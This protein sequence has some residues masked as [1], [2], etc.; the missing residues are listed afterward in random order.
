MA[1]PWAT[2]GLVVALV[3]VHLGTGAWVWAEGLA[4]PWSAWVGERSARTR[5][6]VGGRYLP[7]DRAQPWRFAST[8]W[9]H[10]DLLHLLVN[11]LAVA[12]V[13]RWVEPALGA[14][15][16]LGLFAVGGVV[17]ALASHGIG[18]PQSDGASGA[19]SAWLGA[20]A[21]QARVG[22]ALSPSTR[23]IFRGPLTVAAV[24]NV[25]LAL[26]IP[27][28][29]AIAHLAGTAVGVAGGWGAG[30]GGRL[31]LALFVGFA[32]VSVGALGWWAGMPP[33]S[34]R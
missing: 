24:L 12:W 1:R 22:G 4:E 25:V 21:I 15:R 33:V 14:G 34:A 11:G 2:V 16:L 31:G 9:L 26:A 3:G 6:L 27:S 30:R 28:V 20:A 17:G 10:V 5:I 19:L 13:G 18:V 7:L 29:D 32:G 23:R 8:V